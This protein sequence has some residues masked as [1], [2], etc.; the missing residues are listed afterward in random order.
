MAHCLLEYCVQGTPMSTASPDVI[1]E[2]LVHRLS[3]ELSLSPAEIDPDESFMTYG[4]GS[5]EG[6]A[7]CG[8]IETTFGCS[9]PVNLVWDYPTIRAASTYVASVLRGAEVQA[10]AE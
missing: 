5:V 9:L 2:W 8:D 7:I 1:I 10:A 4:I 6:V 3:S